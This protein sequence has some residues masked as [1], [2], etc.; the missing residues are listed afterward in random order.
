MSSTSRTVVTRVVAL[1]SGALLV[2]A[3]LLSV[4]AARLR[5]SGPCAGN[6]DDPACITVQDHL[7]DYL[8]PADPWV[9]IPGASE[10]AGVSHLLVAGA[11]ALLSAT[12]RLRHWVRAILVLLIAT[13]AAVGVSTLIS[14]QRGQVTELVLDGGTTSL[15]LVLAGWGFAF[16][17]LAT[18][19]TG[20]WFGGPLPQW[21][22]LIIS[23]ALALA[24]PLPEYFLVAVAV[25]YGSHDTHPW[26]G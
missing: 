11:L 4:Q 10:F 22:W 21:S 20:D 2:L 15:V 19:L 23:G 24:S 6:F 5:W 18:Y 7:Y 16:V 17:V 13:Y 1:A 26:T 9:Q 25:G 14:G 12:V 8:L 3:G